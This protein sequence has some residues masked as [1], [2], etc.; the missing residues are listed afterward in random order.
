MNLRAW[1]R[2][3][4]AAKFA[5]QRVNGY[6]WAAGQLLRGTSVDD[7]EL[8]LGD[9]FDDGC[10]Y[11]DQGARRAIMDW[12]NHLNHVDHVTSMYVTQEM[13]DNFLRRENL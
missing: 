7:V 1:W 5:V 13:I 9:S 8:Q 10:T 4:K 11:F 3:R 6:N 2:N 12:E